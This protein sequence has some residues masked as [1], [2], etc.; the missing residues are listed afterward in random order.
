ML[1]RELVAHMGFEPMISSLRGTRPRP[2]DEC[3]VPDLRLPGAVGKADA[4][5][6]Y[7]FFYDNASSRLE[8]RRIYTIKA[9]QRS[10]SNR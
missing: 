4:V 3:A 7:H 6:N 9:S 8:A 10:W 2:L 1:R 5:Y